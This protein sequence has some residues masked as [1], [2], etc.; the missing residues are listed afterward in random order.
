VNPSPRNRNRNLNLNPHSQ[1]EVFVLTQWT[2]R[3]QRRQFFFAS[4]GF[5]VAA[6]INSPSKTAKYKDEPFGR[7]L[8]LELK[9]E[10]LPKTKITPATEV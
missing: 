5:S 2:Q 8:L 4:S 10:S 6:G 3:T 1:N 9:G 7:S